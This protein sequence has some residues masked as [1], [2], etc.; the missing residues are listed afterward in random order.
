VELV[1]GYY[2]LKVLVSEQ[3]AGFS[4]SSFAALIGYE[5]I[6]SSETSWA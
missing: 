3:F 4:S 1:Q 2:P 6:P 5:S